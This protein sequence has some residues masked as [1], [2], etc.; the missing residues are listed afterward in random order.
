MLG[1][2]MTRVIVNAARCL[3][4]AW[5][6]ADAGGNLDPRWALPFVGGSV[7][8]AHIKIFQSDEILN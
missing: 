6:V 3:V 1:S 8:G 4:D 7:G 2:P 5:G